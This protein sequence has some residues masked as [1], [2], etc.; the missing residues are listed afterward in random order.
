MKM[1]ERTTI[2]NKVFN[3]AV[4]ANKIQIN[5]ERIC[6]ISNKSITA[7]KELCVC[8]YVCLSAGNTVK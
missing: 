5:V 4:R 1:T 2:G 8:L 6:E 3:E 7:F